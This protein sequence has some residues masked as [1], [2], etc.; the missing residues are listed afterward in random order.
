MRLYTPDFELVRIN[1]I[2][3]LANPKVLWSARD[4]DRN[5]SLEINYTYIHHITPLNGGDDYPSNS[6]CCVQMTKQD[7]R[8]GRS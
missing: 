5:H 6:L 7:E 3:A 4:I 2:Q 1:K 8:K